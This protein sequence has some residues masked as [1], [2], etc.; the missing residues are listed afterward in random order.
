MVLFIYVPHRVAE[1]GKD[2]R[3]ESN[4]ARGAGAP[5]PQLTVILLQLNEAKPGESR[6]AQ[7]A[8]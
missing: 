4:S 6:G 5:L 2:R 7:I 8:G 1:E 3:A